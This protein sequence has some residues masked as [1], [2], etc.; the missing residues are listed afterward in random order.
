MFVVAGIVVATLALLGGSSPANSRDLANP[1]REI[2]QL[3]T[4]WKAKDRTAARRLAD[5]DSV[6]TLFRVPFPTP[7]PVFKG[8]GCGLY[9]TENA[10]NTPVEWECIYE[11]FA[12]SGTRDLVVRV[13]KFGSRFRIVNVNFRSD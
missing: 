6:Q 4:A 9:S 5:A 11:Y 7:P 1:P 13:H 12:S 3:F 10:T 8:G 2:S